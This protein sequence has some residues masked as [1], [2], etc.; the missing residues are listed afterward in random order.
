LPR[1]HGVPPAH[2]TATPAGSAGGATFLELRHGAGTPPVFAVDAPE[3]SS[4]ETIYTADKRDGPRFL[5]LCRAAL[6]IRGALDWQPDVVHC[7]DW[8]GALVPPLLRAEPDSPPSVLTVHNIGYQGVFAT[9]ALPTGATRGLESLVETDERGTSVLNFL[10]SGIRCADRIT[11]V[12]PRYAQEIQS[13]A[14]YGMG[15]ESLLCERLGLSPQAPVVGVVTR[16]FYQK[17]IDLLV[18]ALPELLARTS[19]QF[20]LLGSG[21][22]ELEQALTSAAAANGRVSFVRGYDEP[23]AHSILAGSDLLLVPSRYEPCGL[24]QMYALRYGTIPVVRAT[25]G[26]ADT[27]RHFH[28]DSGRGNGSVFEHAD[29][30]GVIWGIT[31][32]L[33]WLDEP[34]LRRR[35]IDNAMAADFSWTRQCRE[36]EALYEALLTAP[37]ARHASVETSRA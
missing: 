11:T 29:V 27:I 36:Y 13:S 16:L 17:G 18:A 15:L 23:L 14:E 10:K 34:E 1:Y 8:H 31:T 9:S 35:L 24:T 33:S 20:A 12:S 30:G 25:G 19:A 3:Y 21:D 22:P 32:A 37:R 2:W 7:H 4:V 6:D 5:R 26:L 28:P